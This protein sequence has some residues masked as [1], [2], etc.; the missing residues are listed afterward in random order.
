M[1]PR[2]RTSGQARRF[3]LGLPRPRV[4]KPI[5]TDT[6]RAK[7]LP[8]IAPARAVGG[9]V[10]W[11]TSP[12]LHDSRVREGWHVADCAIQFKGQF[13]GHRDAVSPS[14]HSA[15]PGRMAKKHGTGGVCKH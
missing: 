9:R 4:P 11:I 13:T 5:P 3:K 8:H 14:V 10:V 12:W 2:V 1:V 15:G 6:R 7:D